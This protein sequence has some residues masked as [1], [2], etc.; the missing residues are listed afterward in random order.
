MDGVLL[1]NKPKGLGSSSLVYK[2]RRMLGTKD[3]GH[4]GTLDPLAEGLMIIVIG[5]ALKISR[6]LLEN[7]KE[8]IA[9]LKL[10]I[11]TPTLDLES[12]I[13]EKKEVPNYSEKEIKDVLESFL[14]KSFQTP[15]LYSALSVNGKKLYEYARSNQKVEVKSREIEIHNIT[16]LEFKE[17]EIKFKV[18]CSKGTYIRSLCLDIAKKLNNIGC[19][20]SLI[21]TKSGEYLIE[22]S[23]TL[24]DMEKGN[25]NLISIENALKSSFNIQ[26]A[27]DDELKEIKYGHYINKITKGKT[28][29]LDKDRT[30]LGMYEY[31]NEKKITKCIRLF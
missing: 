20:T 9:T 4:C 28:L 23:Y 10:G 13:V 15:P 12:E 24:E 19:M 17:D 14:G 7:R 1:V 3:I 11:L 26:I 22:N 30:P 5:K 18:D 31:D 6:F 16:L 27:T 25:F 21:R 29:Y 2:L 8:Y